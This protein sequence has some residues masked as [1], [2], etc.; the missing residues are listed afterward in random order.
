MVD[1]SFNAGKR[2][3]LLEL[4]RFVGWFSGGQSVTH[5]RNG[6]NEKKVRPMMQGSR[7]DW[8][9]SV[10][11]RGRYTRQAGYEKGAFDRIRELFRGTSSPIMEEKNTRVLMSHM[12]MNS[13]DVDAGLAQ[14][15]ERWL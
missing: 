11:R 5:C 14:R 1:S 3:C 12:R 4:K 15:F 13:D 2:N 8:S 10:R 6:N 7:F 9:R